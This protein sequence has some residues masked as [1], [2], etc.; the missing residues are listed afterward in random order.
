MREIPR[1]TIPRKIQ[2]ANPCKDCTSRYQACWGSCE[3]YIAWR[4]AVRDA[5]AKQLK[6]KEGHVLAHKVELDGREKAIKK[7]GTKLKK[8]MKI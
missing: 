4:Q 7:M 8:R 5:R 2:D 6:D 1:T 3:K